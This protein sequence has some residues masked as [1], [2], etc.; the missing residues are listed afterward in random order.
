MRD[1][2]YFP[3]CESCLGNSKV[4][5]KV[6]IPTKNIVAKEECLSVFKTECKEVKTILFMKNPLKAKG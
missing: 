4:C 1:S 3:I 6:V 5:E 2:H